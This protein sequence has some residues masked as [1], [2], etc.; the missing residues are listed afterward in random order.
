MGW[1]ISTY[2]LPRVRTYEA[3]KH[4]FDGA[5]PFNDNNRDLRRLAEKRDTH[6]A[7]QLCEHDQSISFLLYSTA[8]VTYWPDGTAKVVSHD[9]VSSRSFLG[10]FMPTRIEVHNF[11][12]DTWFKVGGKFYRGSF[13]VT[14]EGEVSGANAPLWRAVADRKKMAAARASISEFANWL[15]V[16]REVTRETRQCTT[17]AASYAQKEDYVYWLL[18]G[19]ESRWSEIAN[20]ISEVSDLYEQLYWAT[21]AYTA[22]R[23]AVG[24][25]PLQKP[26]YV[27][28]RYRHE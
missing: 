28:P 4:T 19:A 20:G 3:A 7:I 13:T 27:P 6:K 2:N 23:Q 9:T 1:A 24:E 5:R 10:C 22:Q 15:K 12:G 16:T 26:I 8:L 11:K 17:H 21:G 25:A 18:T 14:P